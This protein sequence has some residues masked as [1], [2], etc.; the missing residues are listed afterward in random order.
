MD[1]LNKRRQLMSDPQSFLSNLSEEERASLSHQEL[2]TLKIESEFQH[3]L[4]KA[5][6]IDV[7]ESLADKM[8]LNQQFSNRKSK[9]HYLSMAASV[10]LVLL[11]GLLI[12]TNGDLDLSA[13]A[14]AH[15]EREAEFLTI[16][17][18]EPLSSVD[19]SAREIGLTL[20]K[21]KNPIRIAL[22]CKLG[23]QQA[24]HIVTNVENTPVSLLVTANDT[25]LQQSE[26]NQ[27]ET[28][29]DDKRVGKLFLRNSTLMFVIAENMAIVDTFIAQLDGG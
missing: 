21:I 5:Y 4:R 26:N 29:S 2:E 18:H 3:S 28:F 11:A 27:I 7:D 20:P 15:V 17:H 22:K 10:I 16:D 25:G 1:E 8:I 6:E 14:L 19:Q 23:K 9:L 12:P 24:M 13:Q